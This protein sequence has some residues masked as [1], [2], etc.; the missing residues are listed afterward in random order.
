MDILAFAILTPPTLGR[1]LKVSI[2][3]T[4]NSQKSANGSTLEFEARLRA[5]AGR[6]SGCIAV[7][8]QEFNFT[9]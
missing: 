8:G 2:M 7:D 9:T 3:A 6:M 1:T 4:G 5:A